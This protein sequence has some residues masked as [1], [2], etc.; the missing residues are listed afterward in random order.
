M[1][2]AAAP[3]DSHAREGSLVVVVGEGLGAGQ[4]VARVEAAVAAVAAPVADVAAFD[5]ESVCRGA[6][7]PGVVLSSKSACDLF[8]GGEQ[9]TL[10]Q[11]TPAS[12]PHP[13]RWHRLFSRVQYPPSWRSLLRILLISSELPVAIW[14]WG[15]HT[16]GP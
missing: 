8:L 13:S 1:V 16:L 11:Y 3:A 14:L 10:H 4:G 6:D 12:W 15:P 2:P 9:L 5:V 7:V